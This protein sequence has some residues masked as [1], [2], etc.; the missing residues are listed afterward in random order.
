MNDPRY[1]N[2]RNILFSEREAQMFVSCHNSFRKVGF[3]HYDTLVNSGRAACLRQI[4]HLITAEGKK[5]RLSDLRK[6]AGKINFVD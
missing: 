1:Q 3:Y 4:P 2:E 5:Y 6:I